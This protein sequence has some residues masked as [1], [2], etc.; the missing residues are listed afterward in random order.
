MSLPVRSL[1][2]AVALGVISASAA[3]TPAAAE[4]QQPAPRQDQPAPEL[5]DDLRA[6]AEKLKLAHHGKDAQPD[7][8]SFQ[9]QL[10][11]EPRRDEKI[12]I[13]VNVD[14]QLPRAFRSAIMEQGVRV[15]R[16]FD[17]ELGAWVIS[18]DQVI[19]VQGP[20]AEKEIDETLQNVRMCQLLLRFLDPAKLLTSLRETSPVRKVDLKVFRLQ[21]P[22]CTQ[23]E[24]VLD[25]FP[26]YLLGSEG[27]ARL[28]LWIHPQTEQLLAVLTTPLDEQGKAKGE[29]EFITLSDYQLSGNVHL[30][31]KLNV[32]RTV[33]PGYEL[34]TTVEV[35]GLTLGKEFKPG[36]F[37][38]P[39]A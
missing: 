31:S 32:Y 6:L 29:A 22:G 12:T 38:R 23:V 13:D 9:A 25:R 39:K 30:P 20:E 19:K 15:E 34:L 33:G 36:H 18:R 21:W 11:I 3:Q 14:F 7:W 1:V 27:S 35:R 17:P 5:R 4:P 37:A 24:G 2:C 28:T 8:K 10:R 16:G 26:T